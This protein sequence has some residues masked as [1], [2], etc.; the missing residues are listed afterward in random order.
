[1]IVDVGVGPDEVRRLGASQ[2]RVRKK[3]DVATSGL[4][5]HL[6]REP[7][8]LGNPQV[9]MLDL[10][11]KV[12]GQS[13]CLEGHHREGQMAD[14]TGCKEE[15]NVDGADQRVDVQVLA[16]S[17]YQLTHCCHRMVAQPRT[18]KGH[19]LPV[20]DDRPELLE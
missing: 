20:L 11:A 18:S 10:A 12:G 9:P 19:G 16:A 8:Q 6:H 15:V 13:E 1:M 4:K 3:W 17:A 14:R 7:R 2:R 5:R